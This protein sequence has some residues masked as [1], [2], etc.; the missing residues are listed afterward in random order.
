MSTEKEGLVW[1]FSMNWQLHGNDLKMLV[2]MHL[3]FTRNKHFQI[4]PAVCECNPEP[5]A[6]PETQSEPRA[7]PPQCQNLN[8]PWKTQRK[9]SF[10][11]LGSVDKSSNPGSFCCNS[12]APL[13][14]GKAAGES[15]LK[16]QS[17]LMAFITAALDAQ[18]S[19]WTPP[20]YTHSSR[21]FTRHDFY[22]V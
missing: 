18:H 19:S 12:R 17:P 1:V 6:Q 16:Q 11:L 13:S 7:K 20:H 9:L 3:I 4:H 22:Q 21:T 2:W 5:P 15:C 14:S 10:Y 8:T